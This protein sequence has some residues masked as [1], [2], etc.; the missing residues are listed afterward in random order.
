MIRDA[1]WLA[2]AMYF[3]SGVIEASREASRSGARLQVMDRCLWSTLAVH[4]AHDPQRLERLL[5]LL[6]LVAD[7]MKVPDLTI[8][9]EAK[10]ATCRRRIAGKSG[11]EQALDAASPDDVDFCRRE[12]EF[13]HWLAEQGANVVFLSADRGDPEDVCRRAADLIR[14]S[15]PCCVC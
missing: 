9:L 7:R 2:S 13:Y 15:F 4:F 8:V 1:D 5:P 10:A 11:G 14:E 6:D 12:R 3:L